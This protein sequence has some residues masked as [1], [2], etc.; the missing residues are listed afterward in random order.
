[1]TN[2]S[3]D[4]QS[5]NEELQTE[6]SAVGEET[7]AQQS[8]AEQ[9]SALQPVQPQQPVQLQQSVQQPVQQAQYQPNNQQA[10]YSQQAAPSQQTTQD[11]PKDYEEDYSIFGYRPLKWNEEKS[12]DAPWWANPYTWDSL[13]KREAERKGEVYKASNESDQPQTDQVNQQ[14]VNQGAVQPQQPQQPVQGQ[15]PA[16][17]QQPVQPQQP[18]QQPVQPVQPQQPAQPQQ[19]QW[20]QP[21]GQQQW[22]QPQQGQQPQGWVPQQVQQQWQQQGQQQWQNPQQSGQMP[23]APFGAGGRHQ[24]PNA[25]LPTSQ[26][27]MWGALGFVGGIFGMLAVWFITAFWAP[28]QRRQA[29]WAAWIGF[30]IDVVL[31]L[32]LINSG[33]F[34]SMFSAMDISSMSSSAGSGAGTEAGGSAFG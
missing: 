24:D 12:P 25:S 6:A 5:N 13:K 27:V 16:Q 15:Q 11:G 18:A 26:R 20:Q 23:G 1:M 9:Q 14:T 22:Q 30:A 19:G 31:M 34:D 3:K 32:I 10:Q 7:S 28:K 33:F 29:V 17:G 4:N 21:Q 8:S 2:E